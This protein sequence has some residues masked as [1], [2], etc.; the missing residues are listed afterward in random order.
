[1]KNKIEAPQLIDD[2]PVCTSAGRASLAAMKSLQA[3]D[4]EIAD[5]SGFPV[6]LIE[7]HFAKHIT[8]SDTGDERL[9]A[10]LAD[11]SE[12]YLAAVLANNLGAAASALSVRG[13][14]LND[15]RRR[16]ESSA[17][18]KS[19]LQGAD[20]RDPQTFPA[21]LAE[22]VRIYTEEIVRRVVEF[23]ATT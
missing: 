8:A 10:A 13:R 17:K 4:R 9:D 20:P 11:C 1:M 15:L 16:K 21:E 23:E 14:L 3:S 5:A 22:W 18:H 2:C 19:L 12:L 6:E 7:E